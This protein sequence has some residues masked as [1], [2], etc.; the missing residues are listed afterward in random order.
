LQYILVVV[1]LFVGVVES[2]RHRKLTVPGAIA[3]G[4]IGFFVFIGGGFAGLA[5]LAA[6]FLFG[7]LATSWKRRQKA[8][9]GMAQERSGKRNLGQVLANGG[10]GGLLGLLVLFFPQQ[11]STFVLMMAGAFSSAMADTLSSELGSLYGR[12]FYNIIT[13]KKDKRGLDGVVSLEGTAIGVFGSAIV[14]AIYS[15]GFGWDERFLWIVFA[16]TV[17]NLVD[18][19]LGATLERKG[20]LHNDVVNFSNTLIAALLVWLLA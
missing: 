11:A 1:I 6:F 5:M 18:S 15:T 14:A 10:V 8:L 13:F 7:T 4:L 20:I 12:K 17:G 3:G 16:G 19:V 9:I 2:I